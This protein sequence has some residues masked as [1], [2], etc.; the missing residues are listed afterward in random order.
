MSDVHIRLL[1]RVA[2]S[3]REA[4]RLSASTATADS[5]G[6]RREQLNEASARANAQLIAAT[7]RRRRRA[8]SRRDGEGEGAPDS[9]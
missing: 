7:N 5:S 8:R 9:G 2:A 6:D 4:A 3:R 1:R